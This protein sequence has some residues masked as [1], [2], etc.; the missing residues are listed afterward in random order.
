MF[1]IESSDGLAWDF[2]ATVDD[3]C[4]AY[5][6]DA[7][8]GDDVSLTALPHP[9]PAI[10][11]ARWLIGAEAELNEVY[12]QAELEERYDLA[13]T[14]PAIVAATPG[15]WR[16]V[17]AEPGNDALPKLR[18]FPSVAE[19]AAWVALSV[20][21][22]G[23]GSYAPHPTRAADSVYQVFVDGELVN[24]LVEPVA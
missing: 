23:A 14:K 17:E 4:D 3:A 21:W 22:E 11:E 9:D 18:T 7:Y 13:N 15:R 5:A 2:Y 16:L 24:A 19:A 20:G 12:K 6:G 8:A 10:G 1:T